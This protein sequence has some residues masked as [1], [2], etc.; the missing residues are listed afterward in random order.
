MHRRGMLAGLGL[1]V[2][3]GSAARAAENGSPWLSPM[4]PSGTRAGAKLVRLPG[5]QPLIQLSERP[6]NYEAPI[7]TFRNAVTPNDE[8][9]VRYHLAGIPDMDGLAKW[10]LS[11][12]GD[13]AQ[14]SLHF[15]SLAELRNG[16]PEHEVTAVC[17]CSG[18]RRGLSD[19]HVAGVEWGYG[20][21]GSAVWRGVRLKDV[22]AKAGIKSGAVEI[23]IH[24]MDGPVLPTTPA[25]HKSLPLDKATTDEV[26]IAYAMNGTALPHYN[27]YPVRLVV[28]GWTAT[29]WMKHLSAIE[30]SSKPQP[31]F[32]MQKAY[33]VPAGMFPVDTAF[34]SQNDAKSWPIT[35]MVVNSVIADP[36]DGAQ[37]PAAG[38]T[39]HG[40]AWDRGH[41]IR[42][43][44]ISID[45]GRTW[46]LARLDKEHGH[47]AF[48]AFSF[49]TGKLPPGPCTIAARATSKAGET[50]AEKLKWNPAGY[51]NNVPQ[52]LTVT[53][54]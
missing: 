8:F 43:V 31:S 6:P 11:I 1:A 40:M 3:G 48:R 10:S 30:I 14:R 47:F 27:G 13:A 20:A 35:E 2:L 16:F 50:Q 45:G 54:A 29:Y 12:G 26:L 52:T 49:S 17:Q 24:G 44:E 42:S 28:P 32:W 46:H 41:G 33:R 22:L 18:N 7:E 5:K 25:F 4:Q 36:I 23:W 39:V 38:F 53:V 51:H 34:A 19:P 15:A 21:M 9:F 37:V